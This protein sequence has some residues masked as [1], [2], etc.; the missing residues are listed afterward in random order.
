MKDGTDT[1]ARTGDLFIHKPLIAVYCNE[2]C[3]QAAYVERRTRAWRL[4]QIA[5]DLEKMQM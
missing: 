1:P 3:N 2:A 4:L 5:E